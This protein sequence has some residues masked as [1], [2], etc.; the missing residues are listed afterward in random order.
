MKTKRKQLSE[1]WFDF[2]KPYIDLQ[3]LKAQSSTDISFIEWKELQASYTKLYGKEYNRQTGYLNECPL[4][5]E[6]GL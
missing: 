2:M 5:D 4:I 1:R 6:G 3:M